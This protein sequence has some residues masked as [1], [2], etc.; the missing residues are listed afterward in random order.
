MTQRLGY[1]WLLA[2]LLIG[3]LNSYCRADVLGNNVFVVA[4]P[5][6]KQLYSKNQITQMMQTYRNIEL[7][8]TPTT[9]V[10]TAGH[11]LRDREAQALLAILK[12][13]YPKAYIAS[14]SDFSPPGTPVPWLSRIKLSDIGHKRDIISYGP[15]PYISLAFPWTPGTQIDD[16]RLMLHLKWPVFLKSLSSVHVSIGG[17]SAGAYELANDGGEMLLSIPMA[18]LA[19]SLNE[20]PPGRELNVIVQG[21]LRLFNDYCKNLETSELWLAMGSDSRLEL[22]H[23]S[24]TAL[25]NTFL[26]GASPSIVVAADQAQAD[27][28]QGALTMV[29]AATAAVPSV[30]VSCA[31]SPAVNAHGRTVVVGDFD[32][33]LVI[34]G[35]TLYVTPD[36]ARILADKASVLLATHGA[37]VQDIKETQWNIMDEP[38]AFSFLGFKTSSVKGIGELVTQMK[39][40]LP[41]IKGLPKT[42]TAVLHVAHTPVPLK[43][44]GLLKIRLNG[45]LIASQRLSHQE[46]SVPFSTSVVLPVDKLTD[47][48]RL[49]VVFAY[50]ISQSLCE[51]VPAEMEATLFEDST[52]L[53]G[54]RDNNA[55]GALTLDR[56]MGCMYGKGALV[57]P[58]MSESAMHPLGKWAAMYGALHRQAP[59]FFLT[60]KI[61]DQ[62]QFDYMVMSVGS[63]PVPEAVTPLVITGEEMSVRNPLTGEVPFKISADDPVWI[64]QTF[65]HQKAPTLVFSSLAP[66]TT[67]LPDLGLKEM[68]R[69]GGNVAAGRGRQ[70]QSMDIGRKL[71][72][73]A[74]GKPDFTYYWDQYRLAATLAL[75][76]ILVC[77]FYYM[78]ARLTGK[79]N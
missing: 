23:A 40:T 36:G 18:P 13:L 8:E 25:L 1:A 35:S 73:K 29:A 24:D 12:P 51:G 54:P 31:L 44:K 48:N 39:F 45:N 43:D 16:G 33:D 30:N 50:Y 26:Q 55:T 21:S 71:V 42:L 63:S 77:F 2:A 67:P 58:S 15:R 47:Q 34:A 79:K 66:D 75:A 17:I 65:R 37:T 27:I 22:S 68:E 9:I 70:W 41:Q 19:G 62:M 6:E 52:L 14:R 72:A 69:L 11:Y 7:F 32:R 38:L 28:C 4:I 3:V 5:F 61:S 46:K 56:I 76:A 64:I 57:V 10:A 78:Y 60:D 20:N 49:E 59:D 74:P 53:I